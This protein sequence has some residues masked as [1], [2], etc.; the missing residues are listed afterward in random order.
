MSV[1]LSIW[2]KESFYAPQ[3][4]IIV[5]AGLMGLWTA[6]ELKEKR[7]SLR[8]TLLER[9]TTPLGASTRNAGFACFGSPTELL[10]DA[11]TQGTDDMLAIAEM[12]Y[13]GIEKIRAHF[14]DTAIGFDACGG[15]ECINQDYTHW[16]ELP[17]R[18]NWLNGL[19]KG[20]TGKPALFQQ[21]NHKL[22]AMGLR[23]FDS[24]VENET[25]AALH[26]GKLVQL[27]T[28]KVQA[29]GV[30]ILSGLEVSTI[31]KQNNSVC[32]TTRQNHQFTAIHVL[33]CTNAFTNELAPIAAIQPARGQVIV[34]SP[35]PNLPMKGSFHFDEGFYYW[36]NLGDRILLGGARNSA[37]EAEAT[38]DLTGSASVRKAL[39]DF[40]AQHLHPSF[41]YRIDHHWSGIMGF[42]ADKRPYTARVKEGVTA[43][44]ACNGMGVA[45]T[46]IVAEKL[47]QQLL[48]Y[49]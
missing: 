22:A 37:F 5:G 14:T 28:Q 21:V 4:I 15:Y 34:T 9:N 29:A 42:T 48:D 49:F 26:S 43:A 27:L 45:L 1:V 16:Q 41:Q 20:I 31:E 6:L 33:L 24:L 11:D 23:G 8:V 7:P 3:D 17:D 32:I 35:I 46:P 30:T 18:L 39:E 47:S 12:R 36:R 2:E 44:I 40:L 13:R 10:H 25:E 19:L 38:T